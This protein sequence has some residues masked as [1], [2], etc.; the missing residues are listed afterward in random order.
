MI[1]QVT[2]EGYDP[3]GIA[4]WLL[5]NGT[6][7]ASRLS[8]LLWSASPSP[9]SLV[10]R[11]PSPSHPFSHLSSFRSR[12]PSRFL[13]SRRSPRSQL[14][15]TL[16]KFQFIRKVVMRPNA[17]IR[18]PPPSLPPLV[19]SYQLARC[20]HERI[21]AQRDVALHRESSSADITNVIRD[22]L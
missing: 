10:S 17:Q 20:K 5:L 15:G 16:E 12:S 6:D 8:T 1:S 9:R 14:R 4:A 19:H 13:P 22:V 18:T 11:I 3:N 21:V 2:R 7:P